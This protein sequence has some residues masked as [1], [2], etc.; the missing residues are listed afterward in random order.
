M[1]SDFFISRPRFAFVISIVITLAGA[2]ALNLLPI[3]E[4]PNITPPQVR[5]TANYSGANAEVVKQSIAIPIEEQVNGVDDMLYMSSSSSNDGSYELTVTFAVG[6]DPDTAAVNVQNRVAIATPKLPSDVT[7]TGVVTRKQSSSML[8][9]VNVVSPDESR[10]AIFLSNYASINIEG[11]LSRLN[12]VGNV[13]QF[14]PLDYG[15]RVWMDSDRMTALSITTTDVANAI[16]EQNLL[17]T[18]GSLGAPPFTSESQFQLSIQAKGRLSTV[19]EFGDIIIRANTDGSFIRLRD[20]SRIELGAQS[21]AST[22]K[23]NN[24]PSTAIAVYLS[25]GANA[26]D[27]A[28]SVYAE[29][30][31]L[32]KRYP[33]GVETK[34]IYDTTR[35]VRASIEEVV[36]T[37]FITFILV[38]IVTFMFLADWRATLVPTLAIPVSLIGTLAVLLIAGFSIN[39]ITLFAFILA[40][41]VVVDDSI[42]VVENVQRIMDEDDLQAADATRKAM[43]EITGPVVATT[44]VLL[45]VFVPIAFMPGVTGQLYRQFALTICVAVSLSSLNALTLAPAVCAILFKKGAG[46]PKGPLK[47]F[48]SMVNSGR[49]GYVRVVG[50]MA[51]RIVLSLAVFAIFGGATFMMFKTAPTGF[52]PT[53]DKGVLFSNVQLPDGASLSRTNKVVTGIVDMMRNTE[54]VQDVISVTGFSI[55]S[56]AASNSALV[57]PILT[58]WSER[59]APGLKWYEILGTLNAKLAGISSANAFAFPLPPIMGLGTSGGIEAE[60]Q[61]LQDRSPQE[62]AAAVRSLIVHANQSGEFARTFSTFSANVPQL[63]LD[64]DREKAQVLGVPLDHIFSTLQAN[65]GSRYINDFNLYGKTYQVRIQAE[66]QFRTTIEDINRLYVRNS[67]DGMVPLRSLVNVEPILGPLSIKRYNQFQSANINATPATGIST[68]EAIPAMEKLAAEALPDGYAL[69]WTGTA[70]QEQEA[71]AL[72][73]AIFSLALIFAY[74]FLVAQY[75]SWTVPLS[76]ILSVSIAAFGALI[77][78][79]LLP[80]LNFNLYAQ[81]GLVM[82]IGLSAKSAILIVEFA[83]VRREDGLSIY[84]AA[85]EAAR[86]RFR[87]VMMTALS[88]ILGVSPLIVASGAGAAS[89]VSVGF[90]VFGGMIAATFIGIFFIPPLYLAIQSI[91]EKVRTHKFENS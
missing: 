69:S 40:I 15:M 36:T 60:L 83:K 78:I 73:L 38:V 72:V 53:E 87:A 2:I 58:P 25:P 56:G 48:A 6:T 43:R 18:A 70:L 79:S 26:L 89:R 67:S 64:V 88:F 90:V 35:A 8:L 46:K 27:V 65:F 30:D 9:V 85:M 37:M 50:V 84:D 32:S 55:I 76:V 12:G 41:G 10:D 19:E 63:F 5:V 49:N 52:L 29:L 45:A 34:I 47:W 21:Y 62:M 17:A 39:M 7:R 14:G 59:T 71:G 42:V 54:G 86:L 23:L 28:D 81:I 74:L 24:K 82:L 77:P 4:Y 33:P 3:A 91:R 57:I 75:E 80:F 31:V 44:L 22:A 16:D 68:G 51:R 61:D 11:S 20:I 13:S 1:F 66:S